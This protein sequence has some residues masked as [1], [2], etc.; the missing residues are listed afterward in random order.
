LLDQLPNL[1]GGSVYLSKGNDNFKW[2]IYRK[3]EVIK[4]L[5]YFK[6]YPLRSAKL[7][8]IKL[9]PKYHELRSLGAHKAKES[10]VLG[11]SW[12]RF[13]VKWDNFGKNE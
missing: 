13:L 1:Y 4:I 2:V 12:K 10:S 7:A 5:E 9:I 6:L 8:R 11:K 3:Q